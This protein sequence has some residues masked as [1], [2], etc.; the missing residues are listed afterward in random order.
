MILISHRGNVDGRDPERENSPRYINSAL[1]AGYEVEID[2]WYQS[3]RWYLGH[4]EPQHQVELSY[5]KNKKL[6]CHA[7]NIEALRRMLGEDIHCF[8]HQT[9]DVTLTSRGFIWTYPEK[10]LT[11]VS[12]CI[13][14]K[15]DS[16]IPKKSFAICSDYVIMYKEQ[17]LRTIRE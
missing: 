3:G 9:D 17:F 8:W 4:D 7:K 12:V 1:D 6:W 14:T 10:P 5:L 2:V 11:N 13:L 15:R 16:E